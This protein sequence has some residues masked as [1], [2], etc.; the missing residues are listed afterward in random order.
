MRPLSLLAGVLVATSVTF[1]SSPAYA[2]STACTT[3]VPGE[4]TTSTDVSASDDET[5][6]ALQA[7]H[8]DDVHR[9]STG[10][11]VGVA[12]I[13]SG[14]QSG[15]DLSAVAGASFVGDGKILDGH[16]TIVAGLIAGG[17]DTSG[18]APDADIVSIRVSATEPDRDDPQPSEVSRVNVAKAIDWAV[19]NKGRYRIGVINLSLGFSGPDSQITTAIEA[20]HAAGIVVVA[21]A[22]NRGPEDYSETEDSDG[23]EAPEVLEEEPDEVLFPATMKSVIAVTGRA[24]NLAMTTENVLV[25]PEIDVSAP[26]VGLRSVMLGAVVCDIAGTASSWATAEVSGLAALILQRE[27]GLTPAQVKTR[28][29]LTAQG[30]LRDSATD[31]HGMIQPYEALTAVLDVARDG[32]LR[33]A[34]DS[35]RATYVAP[36]PDQQQD[37]LAGSRSRMLWWGVGAGGVLSLAL[38]LR[39]LT[40]R[41]PD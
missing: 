2:E 19:K 12:V 14:V 28:I 38:M 41:R 40:A 3:S 9:L 5:N 24:E 39:P 29:E 21:A 23:D 32:T 16:G 8:L 10:K 31:G 1:G 30:G 35:E 18:L 26:V 6:P 34:G 36:H 27:P 7:L 20:A 17:G 13:D 15:K 33:N 11:G 4:G 22:G 37:T 25:G